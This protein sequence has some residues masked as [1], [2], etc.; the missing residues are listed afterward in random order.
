MMGVVLLSFCF[1]INETT[2]QDQMGFT[3]D[4]GQDGATQSKEIKLVGLLCT[5]A[6]SGHKF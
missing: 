6:S 3:P 4:V 1:Y 5:L 2:Y